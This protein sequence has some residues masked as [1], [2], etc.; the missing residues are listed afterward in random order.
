MQVS[1]ITAASA[2]SR[3]ESTRFAFRRVPG[4]GHGQ[5]QIGQRRGKVE[6]G[7]GEE[8]GDHRASDFGVERR[9]VRLSAEDTAKAVLVVRPGH[10]PS[11]GDRLFVGRQSPCGGPLGEKIEERS[12][13][14][15]DDRDPR[16][17]APARLLPGL[18]QR[19]EQ[20]RRRRHDRGR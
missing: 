13:A 9:G 20:R 8:P 17:T 6:E 10:D 18:A 11:H 5:V 16:P 19:E 3:R 15:S 14:G 4:E 1:R 12:G 7:T 2:G